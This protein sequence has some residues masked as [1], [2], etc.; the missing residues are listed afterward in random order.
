MFRIP[1]KKK[2]KRHREWGE[3]IAIE[4]FLCLGS[5]RLQHTHGCHGA[6][7][8]FVRSPL[9]VHTHTHTHTHTDRHTHTH[10]YIHT[11]TYS[12]THIYIQ[13]PEQ[14]NIWTNIQKPHFIALT[15]NN[16]YA[17]RADRK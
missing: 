5:C 15:G 1:T 7:L 11:H 6:P 14:N 8:L 4:P 9:N 10:I 16:A 12:H 2:Q 13:T 17:A 3:I